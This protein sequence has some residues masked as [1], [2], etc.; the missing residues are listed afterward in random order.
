MELQNYIFKHLIRKKVL[1]SYKYYSTKYLLIKLKGISRSSI[2]R[3]IALSEGKEFPF[4]ILII[5]ICYYSME[6]YMYC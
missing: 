1:L 4:S 5:K 6:K 3:G 2:I